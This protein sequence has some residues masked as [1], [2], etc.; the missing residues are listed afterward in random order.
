VPVDTLLASPNHWGGQAVG[1]KHWFFI[2]KGCKN[3]EPARGI[4]NEFLR[5]D[6]EPHRKVFEALGA[7]TK[8]EP[9]ND[10]LSGIGFSS[11]R[12]DEATVVVKGRSRIKA[13]NI[14]F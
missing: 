12:S 14:K 5:S 2:L 10:Q 6:L 13:Y 11:T 7:K 9:T 1:N 4:Y 3:P 8:C